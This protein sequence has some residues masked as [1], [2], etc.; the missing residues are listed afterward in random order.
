[1]GSPPIRCWGTWATP[2]A[3]LA[4]QEQHRVCD[5]S[6][7]R[8]PICH[9]NR[10]NS[11][12]SR[13]SA[14]AG[15]CL[16]PCRNEAAA[17]ASTGET[18]GQVGWGGSGP[19]VLAISTAAASEGDEGDGDVWRDSALRYAGYAN[20]VGESFRNIA[21]RLVVPSYAVSFAYVCG[22]T[23]DKAYKDYTK[24][25]GMVAVGKTGL[26]VLLWQSLASVAVPGLTINIAVKAVSAAMASDHAKSLLPKLARKWVPTAVGLGIVPFIVTPIDDAISWGMDETVRTWLT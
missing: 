23:V 2:L 6:I 1:R 25:K 26:D 15:T 16:P 8:V 14:G 12:G 5:R 18:T 11:S 22:D 4:L 24:G 17:S 9:S 13:V 3:A 10:R 19:V 7:A 20:E 21:P